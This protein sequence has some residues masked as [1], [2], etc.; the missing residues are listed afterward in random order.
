VHGLLD[1]IDPEYDY[2]EG[3]DDEMFEWGR[4]KGLFVNG[5]TLEVELFASGLE[6]EIQNA[7]KRELS[8][9]KNRQD[10][11]QGW[12]DDP[13]SVDGEALLD[14]IER[15]GKGRFAQLL[16]PKTVKENCPEYIRRALKRIRD[17]VT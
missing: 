3:A 8:M 11:L 5:S 6:E 13:D 14:L 17:A 10:A 12:V 9:S 16:A 1:L 2:S 4:E 7:L 15:V